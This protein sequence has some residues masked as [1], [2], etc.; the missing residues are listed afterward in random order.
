M[1]VRTYGLRLDGAGLPRLS[2]SSTA[3][4][5][6]EPPTSPEGFADMMRTCFRIHELAEER[7]Y[8][9]ALDATGRLT[10]LAEAARGGFGWCAIDPKSVFTRALL[11]GASFI[12][13][14]HNHPSGDP[15]P[16]RD[17]ITTAE[18]FRRIGA[19]LDVP[20]TDFLI[21]GRDSHCSFHERGL[22]R[23]DGEEGA[24]A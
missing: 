17:D 14:I 22:L 15:S 16:S 8:I 13:L 10:A 12:I 21:V 19:L 4:Y 3:E 9:A 6:K 24:A 5:G 1:T 11:C 18:R 20:L 7:T 23:Q 2:V